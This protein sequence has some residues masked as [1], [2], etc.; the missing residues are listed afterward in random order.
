[1]EIIVKAKQS[2]NPLFEFLQ[3]DCVLQPF[4]RHVLAAIRN[5]VY[6]VTEEEEGKS[7]DTEKN[8]APNESESEG[9]DYLHPSLQTKVVNS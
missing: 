7:D 3:F 5:G 8:S 4:Y 2:N 1:M 9:D 6:V